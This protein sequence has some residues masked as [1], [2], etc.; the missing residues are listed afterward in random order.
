MGSLQEVWFDEILELIPLPIFPCKPDIRDA[1]KEFAEFDVLPMPV[2]PVAVFVFKL[3]VRPKEF[4]DFD[5]PPIPVLLLV[6]VIV[7]VVFKL[8][9]RPEVVVLLFAGMDVWATLVGPVLRYAVLLVGFL[10]V[11]TVGAATTGNV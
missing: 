10:K 2:E 3:G 8:I 4:A 11:F 5:M 7:W 1:S 9:A 6:D